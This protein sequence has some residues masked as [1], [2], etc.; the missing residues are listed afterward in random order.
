MVLGTAR[1]SCGHVQEVLTKYVLLFW[2]V[3]KWGGSR[4]K[5]GRE[6]GEVMLAP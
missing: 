2:G 6:E 3:H 4:E 5:V 1:I